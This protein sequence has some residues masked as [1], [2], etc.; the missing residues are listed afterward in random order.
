MHRDDPFGGVVTPGY[1]IQ[2]AGGDKNSV[3]TGGKNAAADGGAS[4]VSTGHKN[5]AAG[6]KQTAVST[7]DKNAAAAPVSGGYKTDTAASVSGGTKM[8]LLLLY[9]GDT[10]LTP[11]IL[12]LGETKMRLLTLTTTQTLHQQR[13]WTHLLEQHGRLSL[14]PVGTAWFSL[15]QDGARL[16]LQ[17]VLNGLYPAFAAPDA[18]ML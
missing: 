12:Y 13:A 4:A 14:Q 10:K 7:G 17:D 11:P 3:S 15:R 5:A 1:K 18:V 8:Q 6:N 9:R 16:L 2:P